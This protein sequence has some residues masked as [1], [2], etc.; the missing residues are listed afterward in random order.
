MNRFMQQVTQLHINWFSALSRSTTYN[1]A[2]RRSSSYS[3][4]YVTMLKPTRGCQAVGC[5]HNTD[6]SYDSERCP[7]GFPT[8]ASVKRSRGVEF[9][10]LTPKAVME[11]CYNRGFLSILWE[12]GGMLSAPA[13]ASGV[14]H[15]VVFSFFP[16]SITVKLSHE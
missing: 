14:I 6:S 12:C 9:D 16:I 8:D 5:L 15:K 10:F 13:I 4:H 7:P 1:S 11:Y 3:D 2:R